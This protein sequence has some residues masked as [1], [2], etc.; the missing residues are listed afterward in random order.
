MAV[1]DLPPFLL[2]TTKYF[3]INSSMSPSPVF[4]T[5]CVQDNQLCHL[6]Q[7]REAGVEGLRLLLS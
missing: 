5:A 3:L 6:D 1:G 2:D 7:P 4:S